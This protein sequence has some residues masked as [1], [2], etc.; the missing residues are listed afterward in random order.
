MSHLLAL[1]P[2]APDLFARYGAAVAVVLIV[3]FGLS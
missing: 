1:H 3:L 2:D